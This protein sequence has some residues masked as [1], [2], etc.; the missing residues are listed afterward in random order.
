MAKDRGVA[1]I[2]YI[3]EGEC[4]QGREGTFH[5]YCQHCTIYRPT[6]GGKNIKPNRKKEKMDKAMKDRRNW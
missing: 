1:C 5:K 3:C 6:P 2:D 4:K